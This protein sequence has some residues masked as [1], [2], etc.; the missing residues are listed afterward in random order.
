MCHQVKVLCKAINSPD[1]GHRQLL[2][3]HLWHAAEAGEPPLCSE[4]AMAEIWPHVL[5]LLPA[6]LFTLKAL[7]CCRLK[8]YELCKREAPEAYTA[9]QWMTG[10]E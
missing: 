9:E 8:F 10:V 7:C 5:A 6:H 2:Q 4:M 3:M 1:T